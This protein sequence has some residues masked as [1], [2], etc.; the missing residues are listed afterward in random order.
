MREKYKS[1]CR[2]FLVK[3]LEI[4][5]RQKNFSRFLGHSHVYIQR[6]VVCLASIKGSS[7]GSRSWLI[8]QPRTSQSAK[9]VIMGCSAPSGEVITLLQDLRE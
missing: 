7:Y 3:V 2:E 8:Q 5:D 6:L 4:K 1:I 9:H